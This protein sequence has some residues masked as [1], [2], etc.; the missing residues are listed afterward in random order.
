MKEWIELLTKPSGVAIGALAVL[1]ML[2]CVRWILDFIKSTVLP[3][4]YEHRLQ[5]RK[6]ILPLADKVLDSS[7]HTAT[8]FRDGDPKFVDFQAGLFFLGL[9]SVPRAPCFRKT[10]SSYPRAAI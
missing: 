2:Y 5:R 8:Y 4:V 9:N 3:R 7:A 10:I 1:G 6:L